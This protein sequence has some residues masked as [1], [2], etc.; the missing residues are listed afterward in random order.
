MGENDQ[1]SRNVDNGLI[2]QLLI[3][4]VALGFADTN[5]LVFR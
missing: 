1:I 5:E 3:S 4:L 2:T